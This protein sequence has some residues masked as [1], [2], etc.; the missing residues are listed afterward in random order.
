MVITVTENGLTHTLRQSDSITALLG[1]HLT[2]ACVDSGNG[3]WGDYSI[4][5]IWTS[6]DL[7]YP[8]VSDTRYSSVTWY[9]E[10]INITSTSLGNALYTIT[11]TSHP[12]H[13]HITSTSHQHHINSTST[14]H[15]RHINIT[16]TSHQH[17]INI[18]STLHQRHIN[19]TS[20]SH[21]HHINITSTSPGNIH[22]ITAQQHHINITLT[23]Q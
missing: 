10:D 3:G 19:V 11:S 1:S 6:I 2:I 7:Q 14:S 15:Q 4:P 16:S 13:I 17:H 9:N 18:T 8:A 22:H 20:T 12:H 23:S 21:Q 5:I